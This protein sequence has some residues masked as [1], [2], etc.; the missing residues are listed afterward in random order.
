MR[1]ALLA[2]LL[3]LTTLAAEPGKSE[4]ATPAA[5]PAAVAAPAAPASNA[6]I[7][8]SVQFDIEP[9]SDT[10][11]YVASVRVFDLN[12][13]RILAGPQLNFTRGTPASTEVNDAKA[14]FRVKIEVGVDS[15]GT[16]AQ[17]SYTI[18][19]QGLVIAESRGTA[20]LSR[21]DVA[22]Y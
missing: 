13:R 17:W 2:V 18:W 19:E 10:G 11:A 20:T 21:P 9:G 14:G 12:S 7:F 16:S 22:S 1:L 6:P 15:T 4:P 3:P 8:P 5:K